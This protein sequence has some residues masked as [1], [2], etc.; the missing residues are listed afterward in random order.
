MSSSNEP[1]RI[2]RASAGNLVPSI[3]TLELGIE[4]KFFIG[5]IVE[6][7]L[8]VTYPEI[9]TIWIFGSGLVSSFA[10]ANSAAQ[11]IQKETEA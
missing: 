8:I 10:V 4:V 3:L 9:E 6:F 11:S 7:H 2:L 1:G 5:S